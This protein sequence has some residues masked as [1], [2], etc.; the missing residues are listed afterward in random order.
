VINAEGDMN[1]HV[2]NVFSDRLELDKRF[3][4]DFSHDIPT[5]PAHAHGVVI[6]PAQDD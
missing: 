4:L 1:V 2:I 5:G 3:K 6:L